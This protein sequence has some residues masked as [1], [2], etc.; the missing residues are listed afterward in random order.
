MSAEKILWS[1]IRKSIF[2]TFVHDVAPEE[3]IPL[4]DD[5]MTVY[6]PGFTAPR[7]QAAK[8][9]AHEDGVTVLGPDEEGEGETSPLYVARVKG[10]PRLLHNVFPAR[11]PPELYRGW[12]LN[13]IGWVQYTIDSSRTKVLTIENCPGSMMSLTRVNMGGRHDQAECR[14]T[15][16]KAVEVAKTTGKK[17]V[18]FGTSRGAATI[19]STALQLP[20]ELA[21]WVA[22]VICEAPFDSVNNIVTKSS[23]FPKI[24]LGLL[25]GVGTVEADGIHP[26]PLQVISTLSPDKPIPLKCPFVFVSSGGDRRVPASHVQNATDALIKAQP[27][28]EVLQL[29]LESS[30]HSL[31][32]MDNSKDQ[33]KYLA[34]MKEVYSKI[35][36]STTVRSEELHSSPRDEDAGVVGDEKSCA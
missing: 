2:K 29:K 23:W 9:V 20:A 11:E 26:D 14:R 1:P 6:Y 30:H 13:P 34:F 35:P 10:A 31:F 24:T 12:T 25:R 21:K 4:R 8:Y 16:V 5:I 7:S 28:L 33:A 3:Q 27:Q 22:L 19:L 18:L 36:S 32:S 15:I 17:I